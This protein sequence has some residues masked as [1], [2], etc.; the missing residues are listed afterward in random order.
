MGCDI[1]K[2]RRI[3]A[4]IQ[5]ELARMVKEPA[6]LFLIVI[7][8]L[9]LT[10]AFGFSFGGFFT[11][12]DVYKVAI[13]NNDS[14]STYGN[15]SENF[16]L[17]LSVNDILEISLENDSNVAQTSLQNGEISAIL[18]IPVQFGESIETYFLNLAN[19]ENWLN[20]SIEAHYDAGSLVVAQL[21]PPLFQQA[22]IDTIFGPDSTTV[23]LPVTF[24]EELVEAR[25]ISMFDYMVPGLFAFANIFLIMTVAE[26]YAKEKELGL[27][28]RIRLSPVKSSELMIGMTISNFIAAV[29]QNIIVFLMAFLMG[30]RPLGGMGGILMALLTLLVFSLGC[31]GCGLISGAISKSSGMATGISFIFIL[32]LMFL[33]TFVSFGT[34]T[35][36][37]KLM[38]SHYVTETLTSLFLR[39]ANPVGSAI[40]INLGI[41]AAFSTVF[42]VIGIILMELT[43]RKNNL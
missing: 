22:L 5:K 36:F 28:T 4:I 8:P 37:N 12:E 1:M 34:P 18:I 42:F 31:I 7:F 11:S 41:V 24:G 30:Y 23:E 19:P 27:L 40:F 29:A 21:L 33:G 43:K 13:V 9:V 25:K 15:W 16:I 6:Y 38:P 10:I 14:E 20:L 39:G 35:I 3:N 17:N 2:A 32:P 26:G